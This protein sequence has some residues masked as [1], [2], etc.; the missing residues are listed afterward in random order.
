MSVTVSS[1][2]SE[3]P[4]HIRQIIAGLNKELHRMRVGRRLA[5]LKA[6]PKS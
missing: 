5:P 4:K 1:A 6:V 2:I 3:T